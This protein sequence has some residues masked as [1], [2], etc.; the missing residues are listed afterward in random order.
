AGQPSQAWLAARTAGAAEAVLASHV[1]THRLLS[2]RAI[3]VVARLEAGPAGAAG[4]AGAAGPVAPAAGQALVESAGG[5]WT[6]ALWDDGLHDD[7]AAGD[8][9]LGAWIGPL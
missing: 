2:D 3:S 4:A 5:T 9:V 8:G 7:G 1:G 6:Q